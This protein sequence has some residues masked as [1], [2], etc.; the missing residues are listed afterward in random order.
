MRRALR[1]IVIPAAGMGTRFLP[2]TKATP[3]EMLT[4]ANT[5]LGLK[6]P[7]FGESLRSVIKKNL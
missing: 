5:L 6:H 4:I 2:V 1:K 3:K 7:E